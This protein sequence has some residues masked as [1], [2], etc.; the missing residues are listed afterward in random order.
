MERRIQAGSAPFR[1]KRKQNRRAAKQ[2]RARVTIFGFL[3]KIFW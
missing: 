2:D 3:I 1:S